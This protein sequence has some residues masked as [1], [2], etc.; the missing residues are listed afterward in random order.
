LP[1]GIE[2]IVWVEACK[3]LA[4]VYCCCNPQLPAQQIADRVAVMGAKLVI[5]VEHPDWSYVVQQALSTFI[6]ADQAKSRIPPS[7]DDLTKAWGNRVMVSLSELAVAD[8][9]VGS[10]DYGPLCGAKVLVLGS[11]KVPWTEVHKRIPAPQLKA[12]T[13]VLTQLNVPKMEPR[14]PADVADIW[15]QHG[16]PLPVD[17]DFPLFII[18]TSGTT[19]KPKGVCHVHGGYVAG[20]VET[21]K[22]SFAADPAVD[23]MLTVGALGWITG[24]SYQITAVLAAGITSVLMRGNPVK[25][26]RERFAGVIRKHG[27]TIFKAGSAFLR[28][29]MS[30]PEGMQQVRATKTDS[31]KVATFCA[32]PVSEAVQ[33]FAQSAICPA[34]INSYWATEHGG[35]AWSRRFNDSSQPL[36][37]DAHSWPMPWVEA[38]VYLFDDMAKPVAGEGQWKALV[39]ASGEKGEIVVTN[40]Y[41]YMFRYVWGD[42][43]NFGSAGWAGDRATMLS[44]YWRRTEL[45]GKAAHWVYIQGDFAVKYPDGAY[46]FHGRSDE[47]LNVNGLLFGTEHIEGAILRDKQLNPDSRI[48]HCVVVGY[49]D[50][51]AG[52]VA[53]AFVTPGDTQKPPTNR[54]FLRLF[55]LVEETVGHVAVKFVVVS[56][57]PQTFS[58]KFMRRLLTNICRGQPLGDQSTISNPECIPKIQEEFARWKQSMSDTA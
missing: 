53:M 42:I 35:I 2:Q 40:P 57:L 30:T 18:F 10:T 39:A 37:A 13:K 45:P 29:V 26:K 20:L 47:V 22:L 17:A 3:R 21:M 12:D 19:G 41:P 24:Q 27:I 1:A 56:G 43:D 5:T 51:I 44:K 4:V 38:N 9:K 14:G 34:Y 33:A 54:D 16:S 28:E 15:R 7:R 50:Q 49:P 11:V 48:G 8:A 36:K 52:E 23:R 31:L 32:E 58:G 25:P 46:T 55:H 6:P